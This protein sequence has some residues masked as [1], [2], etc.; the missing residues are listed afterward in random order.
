MVCTLTHSHTA[1]NALS[2]Q[3]C[4]GVDTSTDHISNLFLCKDPLRNLVSI[5]HVQS[6]ATCSFKIYM[7]TKWPTVYTK[8]AESPSSTTPQGNHCGILDVLL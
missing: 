7:L 6:V 3:S 2:A 1:R 4:Q 5:S 8:K